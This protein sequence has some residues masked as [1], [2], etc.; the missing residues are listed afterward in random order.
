MVYRAQGPADGLDEY[1][2]GA[3]RPRSRQ[4]LQ[5]EE[6]C[7]VQE[8]IRSSLEK[9][10]K[11]TDTGEAGLSLEHWYEGMLAQ[12]LRKRSLQSFAECW[13]ECVLVEGRHV[14]D[15]DNCMKLLNSG[16][17][18]AELCPALID[19]D[20]SRNKIKHSET[21]RQ[22]L[23]EQIF[24]TIHAFGAMRKMINSFALIRSKSN[25]EKEIWVGE[26]LLLF[27]CVVEGDK[28]SKEVV[29]VQLIEWVTP[30]NALEDASG[31]ECLW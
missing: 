7:L 12:L 13:R 9:I 30:L 2:C 15:E 26:V 14:Y 31:Y 18:N 5:R 6:K 11:G 25:E 23:Q 4:R 8:G 20:R 24:N 22:V 21:R 29:S 1:G 28:K 16:C 19:Y 3:A 27:R 10:V 17:V